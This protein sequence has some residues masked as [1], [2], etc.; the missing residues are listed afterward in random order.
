M[1]INY[2]VTGSDRQKLVRIISCE[3][4]EK[5]HYEGT[6]SLAYTIGGFTV[7]RDGSLTWDSGIDNTTVLRIAEALEAEG[8]K[9]DQPIRLP[10]EPPAPKRLQPRRKRTRA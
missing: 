5:A 9:P 3:I 2:N 4:G 10:K 7:S 6:P 1:N 8:L